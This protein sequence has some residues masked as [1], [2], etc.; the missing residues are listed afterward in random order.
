MLTT[1]LCA[2]PDHEAR[3][4]HL[5]SAPERVALCSASGLYGGAEEFIRT[6]AVYLQRETAV[7]PLGLMLEEGPLAGRLRAEGIEVECLESGWRYDPRPVRRVMQVIE[8]H[9]IQ[10]LHTHG[11]KASLICGLAGQLCGVR[12]VKTEHGHTEPMHGLAGFR[13][14]LNNAVDQ[15]LT[16][17]VTD[18]VV[19]VSREIA[20]R[21][22]RRC[23]GLRTTVIY[24]G[25]APVK[26]R[27]GRLSKSAGS[28][29]VGIVGRLT[30]VKGHIHLLRAVRRLQ[31]VPIHLD[32][33]GDGELW[34]ELEAYCRGQ[35]LTEQVTFFGFR[36][37]LHDWLK[38][39]DL[40]A[41]PSL[42]EGL[43][44][45]LLEAAYLK[46]PVAASAV[47]GIAE[48]FEH[49]R[50]ACLLPP[51]DEDAWVSALKR[52]YWRAEERTRLA[53]HA[54]RKVSEGFMI[55]QM[56]ERYLHEVYRA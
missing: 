8:R 13:L 42:S 39:L 19:F 20:A 16:R 10:V 32:I 38:D 49:G 37:D 52:L 23:A 51:G 43:P 50:D 54:Y 56:A 21:A 46:V 27:G 3:Q 40:L 53:E 11:Y 44:Y 14:A 31:G 2:G 28:F 24:N 33:F 22:E 55:H 25:I 15:I 47:G 12:V 34:P 6:L 36:S 26:A 7:R 18:H 45:T 29:H 5:S 9:R 48:V 30:P 17:R 41:M 35:N 4:A 1:S